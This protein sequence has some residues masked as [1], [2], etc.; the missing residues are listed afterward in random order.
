V[1]WICFLTKKYK[2]LILIYHEG[3][4]KSRKEREKRF[5]P[6]ALQEFIYDPGISQVGR[7]LRYKKTAPIGIVTPP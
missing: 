4:K 6:E 2:L 1:K 5:V 3:R 7:R